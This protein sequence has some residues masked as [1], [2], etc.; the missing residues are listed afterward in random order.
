MLEGN[1]NVYTMDHRGTGRSTL[2]DCLAAQVTTFG[3]PWGDAIGIS[4]VGSC[5]NAL[6]NEYGDLASF[7]MTSAA[8]DIS[9]FITEHS[10]GASTIKFVLDS[11]AIASG[12]G[13]NNFPFISKWDMD[14]GEV[15][16]A[17]LKLC[18]RDRECSSHFSS[19]G[20]F[21]TLQD[22][23]NQ[24]DRNP[25][26]TCAALVTEAYKEQSSDPPSLIL[27]RALGNLLPG[28][29]D[30]KL[31][32]PI[33]YRLNR[34][35]ANDAEVLT[36][37]FATLNSVLSETSPD[38]VY[39][40]SL[41]N[42]LIIYS[43]LWETPTPSFIEL[44]QRFKSTRMSDVGIYDTGRR[45][46]AFTK[47]D[48]ETCN[49]ESSSNYSGNGIVYQ[50]DEYWNKSATIPIQA[51]VL[52]MQGTLDPKTPPKYA[53][54]LLETLKVI[55]PTSE[56]CGMKILASYVRSEGDLSRLDKSCVNARASFNWTAN[57]FRVLKYLGTNDAY[58][59]K[60]LLSQHSNEGIG[61]GE[62]GSQ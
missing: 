26:S 55:D 46:C 53:D 38:Q 15:G 43:E 41:L 58:D 34:C 57:E 8:T 52:L 7:S 12:A 45:Y 17:F 5:A 13:P 30:R 6:E 61:S 44:Q 20:L 22:V 39:E 1:V 21:G 2:L 36:N 11:V 24:F 32:P 19:S 27:R 29:M 25:N 51:S 49:Q 60:Y 16:D 40:S 62:S 37:F 9:T 23:I 56:T 31:I 4:E 48:S 47:E 14:F 50:R 54:Y 59:G 28:S 42:Y 33:V 3:S 18:A 35:E 10:N